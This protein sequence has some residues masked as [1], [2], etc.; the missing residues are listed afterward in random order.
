MCVVALDNSS[1]EAIGSR[2]EIIVGNLISS[3]NLLKANETCCGMLKA[4][5]MRVVS[6]CV[7]DALTFIDRAAKTYCDIGCENVAMLF[8]GFLGPSEICIALVFEHV[9]THGQDF[10]LLGCILRYKEPTCVLLSE[11]SEHKVSLKLCG[12]QI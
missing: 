3:D 9:K 2:V 7:C 8:A 12:L 1:C 11:Q 6:V 10:F 4:V 5:I